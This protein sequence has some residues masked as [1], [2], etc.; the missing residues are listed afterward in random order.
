METDN[1]DQKVPFESAI[2]FKMV[3]VSDE[4]S[5]YVV[6]FHPKH[7]NHSRDRE[8]LLYEITVVRGEELAKLQRKDYDWG[9]ECEGIWYLLRDA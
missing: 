7:I 3:E 2:P 1:F 6:M 9:F 8:V 5:G 4:L